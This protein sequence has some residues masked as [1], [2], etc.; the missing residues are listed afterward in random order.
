MKHSY[1]GA[2]VA[3]L[4][5]DHY[6]D[7]NQ[8]LAAA[9]KLDADTHGAPG[10]GKNGGA[11]VRLEYKLV[12]TLLLA[13]QL[14]RQLQAYTGGES[15]GAIMNRAAEWLEESA[16]ALKAAG[17]KTTGEWDNADDSTSYL[18]QM[19]DAKALRQLAETSR[20]AGHKM[21]RPATN[22]APTAPIWHPHTDLP[23]VT[24]SFTALLAIPDDNGDVFL[25]D[26]IHVWKN[27]QWCNEKTERPTI[28]T[29]Y[30][31]T[32]EKDLV[33]PIVQATPASD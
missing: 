13:Y 27:S 32:R 23:A 12:E 15:P 18:L 8:Q 6:H 29:Q 28:Y 30:W 2:T 33:A 17:T 5:T 26:E 11:L 1:T 10:T 7:I 25:M 21:Q 4:T 31:W 9:R 20:T 22:P 16:N 19:H 24:D 3:H 14:N